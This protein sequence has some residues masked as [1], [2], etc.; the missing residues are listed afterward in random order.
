MFRIERDHV[1][2]RS[3]R[4]RL[5]D[6]LRRIEPGRFVLREVLA[7]DLVAHDALALVRRFLARQHAHQRGLAG[8]VRPDERD[9]IAA[10][11]VQRQRVEHDEW[12]RT[13]SARASSRARCVRSS[14]PRGT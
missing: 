4:Q 13:P 8:A 9:A 7:D 10:L 14:A 12:G 6:R 1:H 2:R 11:D 3:R 5:V